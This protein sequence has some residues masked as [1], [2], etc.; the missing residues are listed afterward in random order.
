MMERCRST[1]HA[2]PGPT[3]PGLTIA[4]P[5]LAAASR[6]RAHHAAVYCD[7]APEVCDAQPLIH[8]VHSGAVPRRQVGRHR[9]KPQRSAPNGQAQVVLGIRATYEKSGG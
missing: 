8:A 4:P 1:H 9:H 3:W 5:S 2:V 6:E 7:R